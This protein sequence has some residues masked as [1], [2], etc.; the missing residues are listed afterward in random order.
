MNI[1]LASDSTI[2][3]LTATWTDPGGFTTGTLIGVVF[4][5]L[6]IAL[7]VAYFASRAY[8]LG[9]AMAVASLAISAWLVIVAQPQAVE[10]TYIEAS[11]TVKSVTRVPSDSFLGSDVYGL[12][13]TERPNVMLVLDRDAA[14]AFL[15]N[16]GG[17]ATVYC[18][19][20]ADSSPAPS[21]LSCYTTVTAVGSG[22]FF[23]HALAV[24]KNAHLT[25]KHLTT[26]GS[27]R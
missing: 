21:Q 16:D 13:L 17:S 22:D 25:R 23:G 24:P 27:E 10:K 26:I 1:H 4:V 2:D 3:L 8:G 19:E 18:D 15:G 20:P 12:R 11:G 5:L 6:V 7:S 9:A 14:T